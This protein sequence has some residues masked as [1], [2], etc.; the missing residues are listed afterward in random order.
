M[1]DRVFFLIQFA[2]G[3][4]EAGET[5]GAKLFGDADLPDP[6]GRAMLVRPLEAGDLSGLLHCPAIGGRG[7]TPFLSN[8]LSPK[9]SKTP[10]L[11]PSPHSSPPGTLNV[12]TFSCELSKE[13]STKTSVSPKARG[14]RREKKSPEKKP[15]STTLKQERL[16]E[17]LIP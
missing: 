2:S 9:G 13:G 17:G 7:H 1:G 15:S 3:T 6:S 8:P 10:S 16:V 14:K 5:E 11:S 4:L 12:L